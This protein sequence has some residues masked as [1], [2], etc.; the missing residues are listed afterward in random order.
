MSTA[1]SPSTQSFVAVTG[2]T[3]FIGRALVARLRGSGVRVRR[4]TRGGHGREPDDIVWDPVRGVLP[5]RE[6]EGADAVVNLAGAPIAERW[7]AERKR[8]I[9]ESRL[10]GT[11][12][13]SR[14]LA[15]LERRPRTLVSG[16]A[17]GYYGDRGD[18]PLEETSTPGTDFLAQVA[19]EWEE[20]TGAAHDAGLRVVLLR[21]GIVLGAHG[22]ALDRLMLPFN[23]GLGGRIGS[24][25]QW[26]SWIALDDELG[27]I[28][29]ALA[30]DGLHGPANLVSPNPVTNA[31]LAATL[32]RV[33]G[34]PAAI[35]APAFAV[36]LAFG[37][38]ARTT[39]LAG[40]RAYPAALLRTGFHFR[41]PTLE[42][43]LRFELSR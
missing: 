34:R 15:A 14:T 4:V 43:A 1:P 26:M 3:G 29:H 28:E 41:H 37:E 32:G 23:F 22:G 10:R 2:A 12:L 30:T 19:R 17:V 20:S 25:K 39:I 11:E 40:Q 24:G 27:A 35:P 31:E 9:R 36:E 33:L 5:A 8:A 16:S 7:T 18:E 38:M 42:Q 13:L 6:L 21:T